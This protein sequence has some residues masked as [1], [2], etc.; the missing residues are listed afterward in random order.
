MKKLRY[1]YGNYT[2]PKDVFG[3]VCVDI[4]CNNGSFLLNNLNNFKKIHAYEPNTELYHMLVAEY[5]KYNNI[6]I[7]NNA[8]SNIDDKRVV[9]VKNNF[10]DDDGSYGIYNEERADIWNKNNIICEINSISINTVLEN[11]GGRIDYLKMDCECGE[12]DGLLNKKIKDISYIGIEIHHQLGFD[13]YTE[14]F[15][16]ISLTHVSDKPCNY[17][18]DYNQEYLFKNKLI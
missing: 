3:G 1:N 15:D 5:G 6:S 11:I 7:Y 14:L 8:L 9:L 4:G 2:I 16:Y 10:T 13:K 17:T 18:Y 12:Y